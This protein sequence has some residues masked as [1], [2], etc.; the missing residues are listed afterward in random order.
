MRVV[1]EQDGT[2]RVELAQI[3]ESQLR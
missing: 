2:R 3:Q 1:L